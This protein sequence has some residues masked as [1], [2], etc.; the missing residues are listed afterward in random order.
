MRW[1]GPLASWDIEP[2]E[3][4]RLWHPVSEIGSA[5]TSE[6]VETHMNILRFTSTAI[7][8]AGIAAAVAACSGGD[9]NDAPPS[10]STSQ[11]TVSSSTP[12]SSAPTTIDTAPPTGGPGAPTE[13]GAAP[14]EKAIDPTGGNKFT[15]PVQ[16]PGPQT[17][18]PG[19]LPGN[20]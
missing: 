5:T 16:A 15:P 4:E 18:A 1:S 10:S 9:D 3:P 12:P 7:A 14:T 2:V 6:S 19:N 20:N 13:S 8:V 11:T 17:A